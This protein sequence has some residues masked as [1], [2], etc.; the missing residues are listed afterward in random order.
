MMQ[1]LGIPVEIKGN[2]VSVTGNIGWQAKDIAVP[3]DFSSASFFITACLIVKDSSVII[4]NLNLNPTRIGFMEV[5]KR[6]GADIE[7]LN[8]RDVCNEPFGDIKVSYSDNLKGIE[9][10]EEE[11]PSIID[12]IP[13]V[14][15]VASSAE[16]KTVINGAGELRKKESDRINSIVT[17]LRKMGQAVKDGPDTLVIEGKKNELTGAEVESFGDHR[18]AMMLAVAGLAS[19]GNTVIKDVKC[20]DTSFPDF[21][22]ILEGIIK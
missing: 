11:V 18:I 1:Y 22:D 4:K 5:V 3:G 6:M 12:E 16:G 2:S 9:I 17:Q 20:I 13:L 10:N 14:A 7:I 8:Q 15:L 19:K 21:F